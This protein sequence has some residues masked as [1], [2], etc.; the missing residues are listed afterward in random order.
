M[1]QNQYS[2]QTHS[3]S[4]LD[5]LAQFILRY[6]KAYPDAKL[7]TAEFYTYHPALENGQNVLCAFDAEQQVRGFAPLFPAPLPP[8]DPGEESDTASPHT[9]WTILLA[10]PE[11]AEADEVR[12]LIFNRLLEKAHRIGG[13]FL[14]GRKVRLAS[15]MMASQQSD[16]SF[17]KAKGFEHFDGMYVMHRSSAGPILDCAL[18]ADLALRQ[19]KLASEPEQVQYLQAFNICFPENSKDLATLRFLLDSPRWANGTAI[20]AFDRQKKLVGSILIYPNDGNTFGILDDVFVVPD[21]RG[22][23]IAKALISEG[24]R[25]CQSLRFQE[26]FLE[27]RQANLPAVSVYRSMGFETVNEE[28]ILGLYLEKEQS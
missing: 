22:L 3:C 25:A 17:L 12:Q 6:R 11:V 14:P 9:I 7:M 4:N 16:I 8:T 27:V 24:L 19:W 15:D 5:R 1:T 21:W 18:R 20:A 2:V 28:I 26:V 23:G 13:S 10:D